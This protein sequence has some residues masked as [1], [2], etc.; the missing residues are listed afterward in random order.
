[1]S[2]GLTLTPEEAEKIK[3][4]LQMASGWIGSTSERATGTQ[5]FVAITD[6]LAIL[7]EESP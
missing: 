2:Q 4:A 6:A 3:A 1:M 5:T 7:T